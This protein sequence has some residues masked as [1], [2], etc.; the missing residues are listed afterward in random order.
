MPSQ[1]KKKNICGQN[2]L[3][4]LYLILLI[5]YL[6]CM[7]C[8]IVI[9]EIPFQNLDYGTTPGSKLRALLGNR[10]SLAIV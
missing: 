9:I 8:W 1:L 2:C 4:F 6:C 10:H 3:F 7:R 5:L